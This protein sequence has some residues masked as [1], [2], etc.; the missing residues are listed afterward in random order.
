MGKPFG[1]IRTAAEYDNYEF[2]LQWRYVDD[3]NSNSGILLHTS[4]EKDRIWPK[5]IQI[6]LHRPKAG[7]VFPTSE[8]QADNRLDVKD[9]E[10]PLMEWNT[11]VVASLDGKISLTINDKK[12]GEVTGCVPSKGAIALQSEGAEIHFQK[13][14]IRRTAPAAAAPTS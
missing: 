12:I 1:Y 5:S 14:W 11:C 2:G 3:P 4:K 13:L 8:A 7:S 10:L 6:Q 9:L